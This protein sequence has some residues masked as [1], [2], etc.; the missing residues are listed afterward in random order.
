VLTAEEASARL[1]GLRDAGWRAA[2][3]DRVRGLR[4]EL[5]GPAEAFLAVPPSLGQGRDA[6]ARHGADQAAAARRLDELAEDE[7]A[8]VMAALHPGL[9]P[10]LARWWTD[11]QGRP[12]QRGWQRTAFR[13]AGEPGLT[14][15]GR[16]LDLADL[17]EC[18]GPF[19]ADPVWL[20]GWGGHLAM[21]SPLARTF[22]AV[23]ASAIDLGGRGGEE[24][25]A[26][27]VEVGH[28]EHPVGIMGHHVIAGLLGSARPEGWDFTERLL[29]AA[30]RQEGLRQAILEAA[31]EGHPGAFDRILATVL[32]H[33]LLRFASAVRAACSAPGPSC[34]LPSRSPAGT[35]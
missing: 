12:Y 27:L 30:Q 28:G 34:S 16:R 29:L 18:L 20:A 3:A 35:G 14:V 7:R 26:A 11:A 2:A 19:P 31:D 5:R 9:G 13:C 21:R 23:L 8:S 22:G 24:T 6:I 10:A 32:E 17:I 1:D 33:R 15:H 4:R 25:L